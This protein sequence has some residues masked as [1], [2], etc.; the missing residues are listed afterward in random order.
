VSG[1][2]FTGR[3]GR[4]DGQFAQGERRSDHDRHHGHG[5]EAGF[6][7]GLAAGSALGYGYGGYYDPIRILATTT[8]IIPTTTTDMATLTTTGT[9]APRYRAALILPI[10]PS[11]TRPTTRRPGPIS[12][13][14][15]CGILAHK[16]S[17]PFLYKER[18]TP[19][20]CGAGPKLAIE[21]DWLWI[22]ESGT[23]VKVTQ[24]GAALVVG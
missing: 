16:N 8:P 7:A 20:E 4:G 1:G 12:A 13:A 3:T 2:N 14:M 10:A 19:D 15:G 22:H 5:R 23:Y 9:L 21:R 6:A 11:V 17:E 24:T 18:G